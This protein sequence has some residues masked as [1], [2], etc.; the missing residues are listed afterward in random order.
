MKD[1]IYHSGDGNWAQWSEWTEQTACTASCCGG[2]VQRSRSRTC[3]DPSQAGNG[4]TCPGSSTETD[5]TACNETDCPG[6][7]IISYYREAGYTCF[8]LSK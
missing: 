6:K 7:F 5:T 3:S 4:A 2:T 1:S 8:F